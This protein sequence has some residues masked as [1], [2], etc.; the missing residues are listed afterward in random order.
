MCVYSAVNV[1]WQRIA[2]HLDTWHVP[3][4]KLCILIVGYSFL[5]TL[6]T[7]DCSESTS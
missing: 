4:E 7:P 2:L 3:L 1:D 6:V 5:G